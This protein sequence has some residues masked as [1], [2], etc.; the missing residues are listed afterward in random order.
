M[1][2]NK[3]KQKPKGGAEARKFKIFVGQGINEGTL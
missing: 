1:K 3:K 2:E